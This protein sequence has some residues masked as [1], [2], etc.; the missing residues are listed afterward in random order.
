MFQYPKQN[1]HFFINDTLA[2]KFIEFERQSKDSNAIEAANI[3]KT[4]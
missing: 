4:F 3:K 2:N 1:Q